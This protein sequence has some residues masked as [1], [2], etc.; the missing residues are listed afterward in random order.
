MLVFLLLILLAG[1]FSCDRIKNRTGKVREN[2]R[3]VIEEQTRKIIYEIYPPFDHDKPDTENNKQRFRDFIKVEI[4]PDVKNIYCF[5]D[6]IGIDSDYMFSF[7]CSPATS[8][9]IINVHK[10]TLDTLNSDNGFMMQND[11]DWWE[12]ERIQDLQKYSWTDGNRFFKFY[13]YDEE[14]K[15]AYYFDFDM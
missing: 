4:T 15:K 12:R 5:D 3:E 2:V 7:N 10:L 11:F 6:A 1:L 13:W 9:K 8:Q 14:Q